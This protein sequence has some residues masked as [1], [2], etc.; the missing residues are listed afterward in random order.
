[1]LNVDLAGRRYRA[2]RLEGADL[3]SSNPFRLLAEDA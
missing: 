2:R 3:G 1:M